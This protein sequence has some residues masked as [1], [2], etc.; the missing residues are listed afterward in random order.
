MTRKERELDIRTCHI[1]HAGTMSYQ[2]AWDWQRHLVAERSARRC[3]D[4][5]HLLEHPPTITLGRAAERQN[6]LVP[7]D[8]LEQRGVTLVE[9]DRGGDVTYHAPGQLVGYPILKL[10]RHGGELLRYL[11]KLEEM[12]I[13]VL[14]S[15]DI[16]AGRVDGLTGVW[17]NAGHA[18]HVCPSVSDE[19]PDS[20]ALNAKIAAIGVR[21]SA[22]GITSHG[23]ALNVSPDLR[24]FAQIIPCG[25][26]GRMVTSL[27]QMLGYAPPMGEVTERMIASFSEIFN[28]QPVREQQ[29]EERK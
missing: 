23:F 17:V 4:T 24:G 26:Q 14:A 11:R 29:P 25:I 3:D 8:E 7:L 19:P 28:I 22:S 16:T 1:L 12:L 20:A 6:I 21:L 27:E 2:R 10:A 9:S 5:L 15:Y 13:Q 18:S